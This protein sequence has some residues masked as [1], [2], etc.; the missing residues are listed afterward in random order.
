M[1]FEPKPPEWQFHNAH[2]HYAELCALFTSGSLTDE[3]LSELNEHVRTC[4]SCAGLLSSYRSVARSV[5]ALAPTAEVAAPP[6]KPAWVENAKKRLLNSIEADRSVHQPQFVKQLPPTSQSPFRMFRLVAAAAVVLVVAV[7]AGFT[8]HLGR[9]RGQANAQSSA[10]AGNDKSELNQLEALNKQRSLLEEQLAVRSR[11]VQ[12]MQHELQLQMTAITESKS[13]QEKLQHDSKE[14]GTAITA[15]GSEKTALA[16][17]RD[18][19]LRKLQETQDALAATQQ[20]LDALQ[21]EHNRQL[22]RTAGLQMRVDEL[23]ASL[24]DSEDTVRRAEKFLVSDR[25]IRDLMGARDLYIADVFDIDREGKTQKPFGRVFYTAGK[26]LIFYAF[27]LDRQ[28]GVHNATFQ[29]WGRRGPG[30]KRPLNMGVLY[31]DNAANKRWAL[32][33]DDPK[34]LNEI[35]AMFVTVEPRSGGQK[36]S[37]RQLLFASLRTPPNH[38]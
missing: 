5:S 7:L 24:K 26:S 20:R 8:Y 13:I 38:P 16:G 35:D 37:G 29:A 3:E 12:R 32:R 21:A 4:Q 25:D 17:E 22:V 27:D 23:S 18:A 31:L 33:F 15:L 19:A 2:E 36:P 1:A 14:Q 6:Q 9:V 34:V 30:D 11:E 28:P 10:P